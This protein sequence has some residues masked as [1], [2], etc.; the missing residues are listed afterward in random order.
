MPNLTTR[1]SLKKPLENETADINVINENMDNID[2]NVVLKTDVAESGAGK[3]LKLDINGKAGVSITG[4]AASVQG[5]TVGT[6]EGQLVV[7]GAGGKL[8]ADTV[9]NIKITVG[10]AAPSSPNVGDLWFDTNEV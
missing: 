4:D 6:S 7:R 9:N 1:L 3:V 10:T 8:N 2:Q 5:K